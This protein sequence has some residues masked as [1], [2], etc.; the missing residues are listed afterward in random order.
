MVDVLKSNIYLVIAF[1]NERN[2][3]GRFFICDFGRIDRS[4]SARFEWLESTE[5]PKQ[6]TF[7]AQCDAGSE[8][9]AALLEWKSLARIIWIRIRTG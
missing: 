1:Q 3:S 5:P 7:V 8:A 4:R 6:P 9:A 2:V